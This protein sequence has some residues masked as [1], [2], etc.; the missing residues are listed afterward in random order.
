MDKYFFFL[1][2]KGAL[3][4]GH[5]NQMKELDRKH[6][7]IRN[8]NDSLLH[9]QQTSKTGYF[10]P[11]SESYDGGT[12]SWNNTENV[13]TE[14]LFDNESISNIETAVNLDSSSA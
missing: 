6:F 13:Q 5:V 14:A 8:S 10:V 12:K 7:P 4:N 3:V 2:K 9:S 1:K 11:P